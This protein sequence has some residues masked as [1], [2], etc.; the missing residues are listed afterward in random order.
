MGAAVNENY[1]SWNVSNMITVAL[2]ACVA[3]TALGLVATLY[4][5]QFPGNAS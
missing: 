1:I 2:M 3:F 5:K 4:H